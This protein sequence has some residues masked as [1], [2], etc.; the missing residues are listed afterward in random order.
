MR[1][2]AQTIRFTNGRPA[3]ERVRAAV[4]AARALPFVFTVTARAENYLHGRADLKDTIERLQAY[5]EAG[6]DVL[7]A[8]GLRTKEDIAAVCQAVKKPVNVLMGLQGVVLSLE[9]LSALGA[10]RISVGSALQRTALGAFMRAA[11]EMR[12]H[13]TFEFAA[14]AANPRE[15]SQIFR[16]H[17]LDTDLTQK[18][19]TVARTPAFG[20]RLSIDVPAKMSL[21]GS[22]ATHFRGY[23]GAERRAAT[24]ASNHTH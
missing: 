14:S 8:P 15:V 3:V 21:H 1:R 4:A 13:G 19:G 24:R 10:R 2:A 12:D 23:V 16:F 17:R 11:T 22:R 7:Y 18:Q 9:E 6:A 5:E 20:R